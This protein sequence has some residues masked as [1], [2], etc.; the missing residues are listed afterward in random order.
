[1]PRRTSISFTPVHAPAIRERRTHR[2]ASRKGDSHT[3]LTR[4]ELERMLLEAARRRAETV[5]SR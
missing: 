3:E 1:M 4:E 5:H 2:R